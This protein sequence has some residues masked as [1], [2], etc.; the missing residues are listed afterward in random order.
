MDKFKGN[1]ESSAGSDCEIIE[2]HPELII[3][4]EN[5][6]SSQDVMIIDELPAMKPT[7][8][9]MPKK[10]G[11]PRRTPV[12][13][14]P[15]LPQIME[16]E[17]MPMLMSKDPLALDD[18]I[19]T[20]ESERPRRTCRSQKSYAPPKRGGRGSRGGKLAI[21]DIFLDSGS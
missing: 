17:I 7:E 19:E 8:L 1:V 14:Q 3:V 18:H 5:S 15:I 13:Q 11:R 10:R 9:K 20:K 21:P 2:H 4:N 6:N 12:V 16:P